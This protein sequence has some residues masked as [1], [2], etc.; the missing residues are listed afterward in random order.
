MIEGV[1]RDRPR[2]KY[3]GWKGTIG[4]VLG[5]T[6]IRLRRSGPQ[7]IFLAIL[8]RCQ[9]LVAC[10]SESVTANELNAPLPMISL[11][12]INTAASACVSNELSATSH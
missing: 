7:R 1:G 12:R 8:H 5:L 9:S 3:T 2:V 6:Q 10:L 11:R 4:D